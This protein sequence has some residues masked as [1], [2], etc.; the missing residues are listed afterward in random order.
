MEDIAITFKLSKEEL[1]LIK[2][3]SELLGIGHTTMSRQSTLEKARK[4]I[5]ELG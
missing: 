4:T 1:E 2:K 3:A 5:K